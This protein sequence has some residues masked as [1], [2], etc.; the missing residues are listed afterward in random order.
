M[1]QNVPSF[2]KM[3][4]AIEIGKDM[5]PPPPQHSSTNSLTHHTSL[6][7]DGSTRGVGQGYDF[8][9]VKLFDPALI[10]TVK[11]LFKCG[12]IISQRFLVGIE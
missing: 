9:A 8:S 7:R 10:G 4:M 12:Q 11:S 2:C 1:K 5:L 3:G 6:S